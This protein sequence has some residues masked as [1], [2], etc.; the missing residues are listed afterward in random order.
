[1]QAS[2]RSAV[3]DLREYIEAGAH[4][5]EAW[6][7][8]TLN[9][10]ALAALDAT[11]V[12][13][14]LLAAR[15]V[16][17][18]PKG[19]IDALA[20]VI[21]KARR[22]ASKA[23]KRAREGQ[24]VRLDGQPHHEQD[25]ALVGS[26]AEALE[27]IGYE[28]DAPS[29]RVPAPYR[30]VTRGDG[31]RLLMDCGDDGQEM[32]VQISSCALFLVGKS[33]IRGR[34]GSTEATF[35][36]LAWERAG[37]VCTTTVPSQVLADRVRFGRLRSLDV[38]IPVRKLQQ[39]AEWL[40]ACED[41]AHECGAIPVLTAVRGMGWVSQN[42]GDGFYHG[43]TLVGGSDAHQVPPSVSARRVYE[44]HDLGGTWDGW[45][46]EVWRE[47][48][49]HPRVA[50]GVLAG[51]AAALVGPLGAD[52]FIFEYGARTSKGKSKSLN[53]IKSAWGRPT[54]PG[55]IG[56]KW[57]S[58][59]VGSMRRGADQ[60]GIPLVIDD[61]K[62]ILTQPGGGE[63]LSKRAYA[64]VNAGGRMKA[65]KD[66]P[67][68]WEVDEAPRTLV[69]TAGEVPIAD[70]LRH[71]PGAIARIVTVRA[72]PWEISG[73]EGAAL[74]DR[75]SDAASEHYG[76]AARRLVD[77]LTSRSP[78]AWAKI[79]DRFRE[80]KRHYQRETATSGAAQRGAAHLALIHIAGLCCSAAW[81]VKFPES[82]MRAGVE[83]M[84]V[85][86]DAADVPAQAYAALWTHMAVN[87]ARV[88]GAAPSDHPP[89]AG[90]IGRELYGDKGHYAVPVVEVE[91]ALKSMGYDYADSVSEWEI[92]GWAER[93]SQRI[94]KTPT[95]CWVMLRPID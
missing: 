87:P 90:Y 93:R 18:A 46:S 8:I 91:R 21:R 85:Q 38:P 10:P 19:E 76:H 57:G 22:A 75:V 58:T 63:E 24:V 4:S 7:T 81:G 56:I 45:L 9:A 94:A 74:A 70:L 59:H 34:D 41:A 26:I 17:G 39:V 55:E 95:K 51:M 11:E 50:F 33:V 31:V 77:W 20:S 47:V 28:G 73:E 49:A 60:Q 82:A 89:S 36:T 78:E 86:V 68:A 29:M 72:P 14:M 44:A 30:L 2:Q 40:S 32:L 6:R 54:G 69:V 62:E 80:M 67:H 64:F 84:R 16:A 13:T 12:D 15:S 83:A 71:H 23:Q 42:P 27:H 79:R 1:M 92:Q 35:L 43:T 48:E 65:D 5:Q 66:D 88:E 25:N 37:R 52:P 53:I 3:D 61:T